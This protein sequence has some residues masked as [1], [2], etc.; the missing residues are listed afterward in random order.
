MKQRCYN[1]KCTE[2]SRYGAKGITVCN[3]WLHNPEVFIEWANNNGY[4]ETLTIDRINPKGNYQP[5]N[6]RWADKRVQ[7]CNRDTSRLNKSGFTGVM[8]CGS[9]WT[10]YLKINKKNIHLGNFSTPEEAAIVRDEYINDNNLCN[11]KNF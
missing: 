5:D 3:E 8:Q 11:K 1:K 10:A 4:K 7:S 9:K 6:C 2:Y